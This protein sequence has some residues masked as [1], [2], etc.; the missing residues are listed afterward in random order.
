M[1]K[2]PFLIFMTELTKGQLMF[3]W[4]ELLAELFVLCVAMFY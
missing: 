4:F 2:E 3:A 1:T